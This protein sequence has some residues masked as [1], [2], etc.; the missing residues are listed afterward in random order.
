V[1]GPK[2]KK[3]KG[4]HFKNPVNQNAKPLRKCSGA[5]KGEQ[6]KWRRAT[7]YHSLKS[8]SR[9]QNAKKRKKKNGLGRRAAIDPKQRK[10]GKKKREATSPSINSKA[11]TEKHGRKK[12]IGIRRD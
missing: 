8:P 11:N 10:P 2:V 7:A 6:G 5:E 4:G 9:R 1:K 12:E 3:K